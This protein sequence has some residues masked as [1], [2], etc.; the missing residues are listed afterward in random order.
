M[1]EAQTRKDAKNELDEMADIKA[2]FAVLQK[3][4]YAA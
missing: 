1:N 3:E 2:G 4:V